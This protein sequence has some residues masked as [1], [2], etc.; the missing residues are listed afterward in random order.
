MK[1][2]KQSRRDGK[3]LFSVCRVNG[4]LDENKVREA[5]AQVIAQ[6]PRGYLAT[7]Q[8]FHRLVRLDLTRC[9]AL[10]ESATPMAPALQETVKANLLKTQ[11]AGLSVSFN[12]NPALIGGLKVR[13]G[14]D[15]YDG[16]VA[17]RLAELENNL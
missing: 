17:G 7:L 10:V 2:S 8:H 13:V 1:I 9:S 12:V 14:S 11:A 16:S 4:V 3:T 5:V 6:K 15:I